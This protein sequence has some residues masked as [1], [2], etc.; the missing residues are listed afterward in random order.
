MSRLDA[1]RVPQAVAADVLSVDA[2]TL[3]R[4]KTAPR[5]TDGHYDLRELVAWRIREIEVELLGADTDSTGRSEGL[6]R[7]RATRAELYELDLAE[8]RGE[9]VLKAAVAHETVTNLSILRDVLLG[10]PATLAPQLE[11]QAVA[12]IATLLD[13]EIRNALG[14]LS[15][16]FRDRVPEVANDAA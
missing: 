4:W 12:E 9:L 14:D 8:R 6:E 3:R 10:L 2:R 13:T 16:R 7:I 5:R 1:H 11:G 15:A